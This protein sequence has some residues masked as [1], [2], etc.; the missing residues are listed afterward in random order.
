[1]SV[2][3]VVVS[4]PSARRAPNV[5]APV[6]SGA[7]PSSGRV[8]QVKEGGD[9]LLLN[10]RVLR[11]RLLKPPGPLRTAASR[12]ALRSCEPSA[13]DAASLHRRVHES[14]PTPALGALVELPRARFVRLACFSREPVDTFLARRRR[15][16][17][18]NIRLFAFSE[19][20]ARPHPWRRSAGRFIFA[21]KCETSALSMRT[22]RNR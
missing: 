1:M 13:D 11:S 19:S 18:F 16:C 9:V 10:H 4:S 14:P 12:R 7:R 6:G 5:A 15:Y 17:S 22:W 2:A 8:A 3:M 21:A 20:L